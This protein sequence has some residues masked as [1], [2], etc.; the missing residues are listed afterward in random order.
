MSGMDSLEMSSSSSSDQGYSAKQIGIAF[1]VSI[2]AG[3]ATSIGAAVVFVAR[4]TNRRLLALGL[5]AAAGVM[6]FV[7]F[8]EIFYKADAEF[9]VTFDGNETLARLLS[10]VCFFSGV[11]LTWILDLVVHRV[12]NH[13]DPQTVHEVNV[14]KLQS[15]LQEVVPSAPARRI[16]DLGDSSPDVQSSGASSPDHMSSLESSSSDVALLV[17]DAQQSAANSSSSAHVHH[18]A[19]TASCSPATLRRRRNS[20][21]GANHKPALLA[22]ASAVRCDPG[23]GD[24]EPERYAENEGEGDSARRPSMV[25]QKDDD[26][27]TV[28]L[29]AE[30]DDQE[31]VVDLSETQK[32]NLGIAGVITAISIAIHNFPEGLATFLS[33]LNDPSV[34][35]PLA[36]AIAVHNIPEG[37]CVAIPI[38]YA[39]GSKWKGFIAGVLSGLSEI[40]GGL[41]A[42]AIIAATPSAT[43]MAVLFG[44]VAGM[45]VFIS[46]NELL[47]NAL[48]YEPNQNLVMLALFGGMAVMAASLVLFLI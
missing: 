43:A 32:R 10:T 38:Y 6:L 31:E 16:G 15:S 11:M 44:L 21:F 22:R 7:S 27:V 1:A 28:D 48:R 30:D 25:Q 46:L 36:I 8:I 19:T 42:Y 47:P 18:S 45:M 4:E 14:D 24:N 20:S 35:I 29:I 41:I 39:T 34:G 23:D 37:M 13:N 33:T 5:A 17:R 3:L 26:D 2:G 9:L 40:I 12:W